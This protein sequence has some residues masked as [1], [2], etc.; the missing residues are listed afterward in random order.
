MEGGNESVNKGAPVYVDGPR[1]RPEN[2]IGMKQIFWIIVIVVLVVAGAVWYMNWSSSRAIGGGQVYLHDH[3]TEV[4]K[5]DPNTH[6]SGPESVDQTP[7]STNQ[8]PIPATP[9]QSGAQSSAQPAPQNPTQSNEVVPP[10]GDTI[11]RNPPTGM[12][13]AGTGRYQLYRQGDLTWRLN[14]D[15]GQACVLFA[16]DEEWRKAKVYQHGC[17][18]S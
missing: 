16:T 6:S 4:V 2:K 9:E 7:A 12:I 17:G 8:A 18:R 11:S 1:R 3:P 13:F 10:A 5:P 15:T 14:T